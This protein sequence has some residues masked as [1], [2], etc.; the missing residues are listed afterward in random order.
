MNKQMRL[1][2]GLALAISVSSTAF[3]LY[4]KDDAF[5]QSHLNAVLYYQNLELQEKANVLE[6]KL[7]DVQREANECPRK[8]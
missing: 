4:Q 2:C 8:R 7:R 3:G 6:G 5:K 1:Y